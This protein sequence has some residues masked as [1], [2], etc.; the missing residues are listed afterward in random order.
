MCI[1]RITEIS[2]VKRTVLKQLLFLICNDSEIHYSPRHVPSV[3][4][5]SELVAEYVVKQSSTLDL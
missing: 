5:M 2:L 1:I 4:H 3:G